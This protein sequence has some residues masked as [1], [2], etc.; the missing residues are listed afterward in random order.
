VDQSLQTV[1]IVAMALLMLVVSTTDLSVDL[2]RV[3][4][5][6]LPLWLTNLTATITNDRDGEGL[7]QKSVRRIVEAIM[8]VVALASPAYILTRPGADESSFTWS[9][10]LWLTAVLWVLWLVR[11][12]RRPL[13]GSVEESEWEMN[14]AA[15]RA[16]ARSKAK[17]K[18]R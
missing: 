5:E 14:R 15:R 10:A 17:R 4:A 18:R 12:P 2:L 8:T 7:G 9:V 3:D 13:P 16:A 11:R 6:Q 1:V